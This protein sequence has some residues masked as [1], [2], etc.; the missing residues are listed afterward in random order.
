MSRKEKYSFS[1]KQGE[2]LSATLDLPETT[3][4]GYAVFAH[5]FTCSRN[6][7]TTARIAGALAQ[8]GI[9]VLRFDF[10]GLGESEGDFAET[11]LSTNIDDVISAIGFMREHFAPPALLIGHS[12]GAS[13]VIAAATQDPDVRA[14]VTLSAPDDPGHLLQLLKRHLADIETRGQAMVEIGGQQF[15]ITRQFIDDINK[16]AGQ[17]QMAQLNKPVLIL[18]AVDDELTSIDHAHRLFEQAEQP[19]SLVSLHG[20]NHLF[21]H[22]ENADVIASIIANWSY[23]Y[24][25]VDS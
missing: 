7:V 25:D 2:K 4:R 24:L 11:N 9:A 5:C 14:V 18:H 13:A 17:K 16:H 21:S 3:I 23:P 20:A 1:N 8:H 19:K 22:Q 10:T 15:A 6:I 12:L